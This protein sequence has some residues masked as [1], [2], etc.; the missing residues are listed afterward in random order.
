MSFL[1]NNLRILETR[2]PGLAQAVRSAR[3][4]P[5]VHASLSRAGEPVPV[6]D[7]RALHS[8]Y[9]PVEE[10]RRFAAAQ[11]LD[12]PD[13]VAVLGFGFGYHVE[14]LLNRT[15]APVVVIERHPS[16][17]R[18]AMDARNLELV[19]LSATILCDAPAA[20]P[21]ACE[22]I[23]AALV[24]DRCSIV[25]HEPSTR[26]APEYYASVVAQLRRRIAH[27]PDT[28]LKVAV[29][30]P[31]FGGSL[32]IA[33]FTASAL[34]QI[35][36]DATLLDVSSFS[37][38][39]RLFEDSLKDTVFQPGMLE[40]LHR[41][42]CEWVYCRLR[43]VQPDLVLFLA[44]APVSTELLR[45]LREI[46]LRTAF[47][48][49]ENHRILSYWKEIA[50]FCDYFF[51]VQRGEFFSRLEAEG[52]FSNYYLPVACDPA[53]H[54]PVALDVGESALYKAP[55]S[56]AG[57][58]Y[59]NRL[60]VLQGLAE[61]APKLWGPGWERA[62][63]LQ[64]FVQRGG[65]EFDVETMVKIYNGTDINLN[66]HSSTH[67]TGLE[68][69]GDFVN[70]RTF[71]LA[72]CGAFQLIDER[73]ELSELFEIGREIAAFRTVADLRMQI[74]HYLDHP[75]E[76]RKIAARSRERVLADHTYV[77][78]MRR[79][80]ECVYPARWIEESTRLEGPDSR[81]RLL[82]ETPPDHDLRTLI[83]N[84]PRV[85]IENLISHLGA[86]DSR[87]GRE[88]VTLRLMAKILADGQCR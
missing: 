23:A 84:S 82:R 4:S 69:H 1:E 48:F 88:E 61:F 39:Y 81:S 27:A 13:A 7:G 74:R 86:R 17:L 63:S 12:N 34:R 78:R 59:Y 33:R 15:S 57:F 72:G 24:S 66:L 31:I 50:P 58:G 35:G 25:V 8:T 9:R 30:S 44:Q 38:G 79:M 29:V 16:I 21:L 68:P 85:T 18:A 64:P 87:P 55:L 83:E 70:P 26:I 54:R 19:L 20:A 53:I 11:T 45:K 6:I 43:Q 73:S 40:L 56:L 65:V 36:C 32:P 71:E 22:T 51:A 67:S 42:L 5:A 41:L 62:P 52:A 14:A 2:D 77:L 76:R 3:P 80:L 47:W 28:R 75:A 10:A 49:V 60:H 37:P 46:N